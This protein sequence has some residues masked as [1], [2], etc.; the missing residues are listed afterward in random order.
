MSECNNDRIPLACM[1]YY[2]QA[3]R[4]V[5]GF[6]NGLNREYIKH[7]GLNNW[8]GVMDILKEIMENPE[9]LM[10]NPVD[11]TYPIPEKYQK[12]YH[13]WVEKRRT[14][15][16]E[17]QDALMKA[18]Q[19]ICDYYSEPPTNCNSDCPFYSLYFPFRNNS[20]CEEVCRKNP[21]KVEDILD[22]VTKGI[23]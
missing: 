11:C 4:D 10:D 17:E 23:K 6:L 2:R 21:R 20:T 22:K 12:K 3:I 7:S 15:I 8:N 13:K 9:L 18:R 16:K 5:Y 14:E 19:D 1:R